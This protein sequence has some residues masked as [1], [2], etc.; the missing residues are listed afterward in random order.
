[1]KKYFP[2][3]VAVII[4]I[5]VHE[6]LHALVA[7]PY[8][9]LNSFKVRYYG[10]EV[11]FKTP[12][13]DREGLHWGF[14]SGI[15]NAVTLALGYIFFISREKLVRIKNEFLYDLGYWLIFVFMLFDAANLSFIPFVFG[16]DIGGIVKGF[17]VNR[18]LLQ[19]LFFALLLF[20]REL[21]I[22]KVFPLYRIKTKHFLFRPLIKGVQEVGKC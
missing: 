2:F 7:L 4:Y 19:L 20:N 6:G 8:N 18:Y 14:I 12:V 13:A 1:L 11:I 5:F 3:V 16:G 17:G 10:F 15:S 9:E 22:R 21:I